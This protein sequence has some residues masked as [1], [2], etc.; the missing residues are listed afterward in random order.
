MSTHSPS[1]D[2]DGRSPV[3]R[4]SLHVVAVGPFGEAVAEAL[5]DGRRTARV[6]PVHPSRIDAA[7]WPHAAVHV[8]ASGYPCHQLCRDLET[9]CY[10]RS[11]ALVPV[12]LDAPH[13]I[14]GPVVVPGTG[15]CFSCYRRRLLQH[16]A[17]PPVTRA[18]LDH[19]DAEPL[20]G[21]VGHLSVLADL[22]AARV[23]QLFADGQMHADALAGCHA[24]AGQVWRIDYLTRDTALSRVIGVHG[25]PRCGL[26][27]DE[28]TRS[29]D[30]LHAY[31]TA[32][33]HEADAAGGGELASQRGGAQA[34]T[35]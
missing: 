28:R 29:V 35:A 20:R 11:S 21:P 19:Y 2:G 27:R 13:L 34:V 31:L 10:Q 15:S 18:L 33:R 25:C 16:A 26:R 32:I 24:A 7:A 1:P 12:T 23:E 6:T 30:E 9:L 22:A 3:G 4:L 5:A 17:R 8:L 14:V